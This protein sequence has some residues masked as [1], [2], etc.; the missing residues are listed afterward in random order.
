M[1]C[2]ASSS[3][4]RAAPA[5]SDFVATSGCAKI[6]R[7]IVATNDCALMAHRADLRA[8][9][10]TLEFLETMTLGPKALTSADADAVLK[11]GGSRE[12]LIGAMHV[13]ALFDMIVRL[14]DSL[15]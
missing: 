8:D 3:G 15:G 14:A 2:T 12:A 6:V 1:S 7:T 9:A 4:L 13:Y 11:A 10:P 5:G